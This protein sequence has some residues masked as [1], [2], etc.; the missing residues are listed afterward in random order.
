MFAG[1]N[2][3]QVQWWFGHNA[4]AFVLTV[5][6]IAI[7]YYFIPKQA[8]QPVY[9]YRLSLWSFWGLMFV[10]LWA[11][12]HHMMYSTIPS[13]VQTLGM[14]FSLVNHS[15]LGINGQFIVDHVR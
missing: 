3:A 12:P 14:V 2:D 15:V 13:W 11:G 8:N 6:I 4:V 1:T 10:Y 5:P 9:S 7:S